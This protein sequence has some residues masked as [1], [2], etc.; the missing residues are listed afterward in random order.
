VHRRGCEACARCG[1]LTANLH[2]LKMGTHI[3]SFTP[4]S[5]WKKVKSTREKARTKRKKEETSSA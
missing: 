5:Y 3:L 4:T 1:E 2:G